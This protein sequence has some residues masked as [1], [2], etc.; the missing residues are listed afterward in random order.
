MTS[1]MAIP[2]ASPRPLRPSFAS[3]LGPGGTEQPRRVGRH[4]T[5]RVA[6]PE[7]RSPVIDTRTG[8]HLGGVVYPRPG[9]VGLA[10]SAP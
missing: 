10:A 1:S 5:E 6:T 7:P 3:C 8:S 9:R 2:E 4:P